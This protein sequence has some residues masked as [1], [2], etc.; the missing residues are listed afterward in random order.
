MLISCVRCTRL[1]RCTQKV[2]SLYTTTT[3]KTNS[4]VCVHTFPVCSSSFSAT[5][6]LDGRMQ[7]K[8]A[9]AIFSLVTEHTFRGLI[10]DPH[11]RTLHAK[12]TIYGFV[13]NKLPSNYSGYFAGAMAAPTS[14]STNDV[15]PNASTP[16]LLQPM[17]ILLSTN[18]TAATAA[19][20]NL[21]RITF[22]SLAI[23]LLPYA[24]P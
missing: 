20:L 7:S 11:T 10:Y 4:I 9:N 3:K 23:V 12:L 21:N 2:V 5:H 6:T 17:P 24:L 22:M 16:L 13:P 18:T 14:P 1:N 15:P 8:S 19:L